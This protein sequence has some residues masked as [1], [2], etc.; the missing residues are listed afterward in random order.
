MN[1]KVFLI[2]SALIMFIVIIC[3]FTLKLMQQSASSSNVEFVSIKYFDRSI[4]GK[5]TYFSRMSNLDL[6]A[7]SSRTQEE[8]T[9]KYKES[10]LEFNDKEKEVLKSLAANI[11]IHLEPFEK[12]YYIPWKFLKIKSN[13]ELGFP[14]T[15]EDTIILSEPFF[16]L[17]YEQQIITLLHEKIHVFQ[18]QFPTETNE[19]I[20][21]VMG[22]QIKKR[23]ES[24]NTKMRN[25]PDLNSITYG[26]HDFYTLQLYNTEDPK[27]ISNS[28][29]VKVHEETL[30]V[31][32]ITASDLDLPEFITQL[33]HPFE[34]MASYLPLILLHRITM[35]SV[36]RSI[37][38]WLQ[39]LKK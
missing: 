23:H 9:I 7:R 24:F 10:I 38:T 11:D 4:K 16:R 6:V 29:P 21:N 1:M 15:L 39:T 22:F 17:G 37:F 27:N 2:L 5:T 30:K 26:K 34:I 12:L 3:Y 25:N 18:R 28:H 36:P 14:H 20:M 33:E 8:Y 35:K 31:S 32:N 13:I 19:F